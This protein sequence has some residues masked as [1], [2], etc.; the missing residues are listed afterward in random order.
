MY[1]RQVLVNMVKRRMKD[2]ARQAC[3]FV[4]NDKVGLYYEQKDFV[5]K[6]DWMSPIQ[7]GLCELVWNKRARW[8]KNLRTP[9]YYS[10]KKDRM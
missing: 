6:S 3:S 4:W 10:T 2:I 5:F 8:V 7:A 1:D 9:T